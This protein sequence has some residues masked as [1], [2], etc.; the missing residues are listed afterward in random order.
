M[1]D[2]IKEILAGFD[3]FSV[4]IDVALLFALYP[5]IKGFIASAT[6]NMTPAE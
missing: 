4:A 2:P 6:P 5:A 1:S 3:V